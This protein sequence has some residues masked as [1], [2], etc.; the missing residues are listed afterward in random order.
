MKKTIIVTGASRGIGKNI[1]VTLAKEG[2]NV[3]LNYNKS[4][5]EAYKTQE[6]LKKENINI[7]IFKADVSRK[8]EVEKLIQFTS[9]KKAKQK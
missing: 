5:E 7:E 4:F 2:H 8:D 1:A 3:V 9:N 6:D